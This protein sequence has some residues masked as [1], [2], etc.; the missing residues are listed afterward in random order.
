MSKYLAFLIETLG[1]LMTSEP[2]INFRRI[3]YFTFLENAQNLTQNCQQGASV[4]SL[5][6]KKKLWEQQIILWLPRKPST[7][8]TPTVQN[9]GIHSVIGTNGPSGDLL[10]LFK[11]AIS[12]YLRGND[13][14]LTEE[15]LRHLGTTVGNGIQF[16]NPVAY[17]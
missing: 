5:R 13:T 14:P 12:W 6:G 9:Q 3:N 4:F 17:C 2:Q 15:I 11:E 10:A 8:D 1:S 7:Q 16:S